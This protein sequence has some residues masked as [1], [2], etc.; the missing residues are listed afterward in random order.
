MLLVT[1]VC[2]GLAYAAERLWQAQLENRLK[3]EAADDIS[4]VRS[5]LENVLQSELWV[6]RG[7]A[8]AIASKPDMNA[9][10][11]QTIVAHLSRNDT[12]LVNIA[13][14][15]G[16]VVS[17][18]YPESGNEAVLGLD[19]NRHPQQGR[20]ALR[21]IEERN[22][23]VAG[24]IK[25]L[26]GG[27]GLVARMPVFVPTA[28]GQSQTLW[29]LVSAVINQ[30]ELLLR[31]GVFMP[32]PSGVR[33]LL[34]GRDALGANGDLF[35]GDAADLRRQDVSWLQRDI[36]LPVGSWRMLGMLP[37]SA[38][39]LPLLTRL[40]LRLGFVLLAAVA[41]GLLLL[42]HKQQ[43]R[44][45]QLL[46]ELQQSQI[47]LRSI[48]DNNSSSLVYLKDLE[49]RYQIVNQ[50][51][52][53][54]KG[55]SIDAIIGRSDYDLV[56]AANAEQFRNNDRYVIE[57]GRSHEFEEVVSLEGEDRFFHSIK[58]PMRDHFGEIVGVCGITTDINERMRSEKQLKE[59]RA[60]FRDLVENTQDWIWEV[61]LNGRYTYSSPQVQD[62]LGYS[63]DEILGKTPFDLMSAAEAERLQKLFQQLLQQQ[64]PF[65]N[66][67]KINRHKDGYEVTLE[68]NGT[69]IFDA[70]GAFKGFRGVNRDISERQLQR[71]RAAYH[72][73]VMEAIAQGQE[74]QKVLQDLLR[75]VQ[76]QIPA[77]WACL[78]FP[79][80]SKDLPELLY[81]SLPESLRDWFKRAERL[82][83]L[84][85][86]ALHNGNFVSDVGAQFG[87][88]SVEI[89][90]KAEGPK[91]W[92]AWPLPVQLEQ[93]QLF[94]CMVLLLAREHRLRAEQMQ[95][96]AYMAHLAGIALDRMQ[97][98]QRI[99]R[100]ETWH[101]ILI[102]GSQDG[103]VIMHANGEVHACN[104]AFAE[105]LQYPREQ[106]LKMA[107]WD[108]DV[109]WNRQELIDMVAS[110]DE[111][112]H[113]FETLHQRRD[114]I[115]LNVDV[116]A[117]AAS[118]RGEKMLFCVCRDISDKKL[119]ELALQ[120]SREQFDL[121][122]RASNDGLWD[123][124]LQ[125]NEVYYS[126][127]WKAMLGY[128]ED[129]LDN[130]F[131]TWEELVHAEDLAQAKALIEQ[132]LAQDQDQYVAEFRMRH[133]Q[134]H[135]VYILSR[136]MHL[137]DEQGVSRRMVGTH[138]D[139]SAQKQLELRLRESEE[140]SRLII[141][142]S[143]D[144]IIVTDKAGRMVRIN[145][146]TETVFGYR[147][148]ELLGHAVE[149]LIPERY[150]ADHPAKREKF[151]QS[152]THLSMLDLAGV[153]FIGRRKDGSEFPIEAGLTPVSLDGKTHIIVTLKD[154]TASRNAEQALLQ[155]K[156]ELALERDFIDAVVEVAGNIIAVLDKEGRYVRFNHAAEL[157]S[158]YS[159]EELLGHS[160]WD[161][162]IP[163]ECQAGVKALFA[164]LNQGSPFANSENEWIC[165]DG[166]RRLID[167][168]NTI[169]LDDQQ[170]PAFI[171]S[172][173]YDITEIRAAE[174]ALQHS[175]DEL[176]LR[177]AERTQELKKS[178]D[179]N[180]LLFAKTPIG[181]ALC[182]LRGQIKDVNPAF[183][184]I[185]GCDEA[186]AKSLN[187]WEIGSPGEAARD[188]LQLEYLDQH[189]RYGPL[190]TE[191][192]QKSGKRV[193]VS[194]NGQR[195]ELDGQSYIWS[196][197]EDLTERR[198]ME[199]KIAASEAT[200]IRAQALA[201]LGSW[202]LDLGS[203]QLDWS[204]ETYQIF[205]KEKGSISDIRQFYACVHVDDVEMVRER[206]MS[207]QTQGGD[208]DVEHRIVVNGELRWVRQQAELQYDADGCASAAIG[209]VLDISGFK[210]AELATRQAL[211][212]AHRLAQARSN[213]LANM[214]HEIR[215]PLNG[216]L[217]L[218]QIGQR[219]ADIT[220]SKIFAQINESGE[221][222]LR[223]VN[224]ILDFSKLDAGKMPMESEAFDLHQSLQKSHRLMLPKALEKNLLLELEISQ[225]VPEWVQGDV[226]RLEQIIV[227]LLSNALKFT[228]QGKVSLLV[229][230]LD[231]CLQ[232]RVVD[233]GIG[234][235][236]QQLHK[237][238]QPFE[239]AD[240]STTRQFG[241][242]GLG[243]A[244]CYQLS[245]QMHGDIRVRSKL[246]EGTEFELLL[247]LPA[248]QA[249]ARNHELVGDRLR[250]AGLRLLAA[251]DVELNRE[252]LQDMIE[253]EGAEIDLVENGELA[254]AAVKSHP[255]EFYDAVLMDV[256]MP[257]MDGYEATRQI[258]A[259]NA[260]LPV[261]GI[262]AHALAEER[263]KA[264][265][266]GMAEHISKPVRLEQ[267][268][269]AILDVVKRQ[270]RQP[271]FESVVSQN[272]GA[273][274]SGARP[275]SLPGIDL[276]AGLN[277][278]Q[279]RWGSYERILHLFLQQHEHSI[280]QL[281]EH[282]QH[283]EL[284]L[285]QSLAHRLKGSSGNLGAMGLHQASAQLEQAC[286]E[287]DEV[288]AQ[289]LLPLV[290]S[291][292]NSVLQG[293]REHFQSQPSVP[294]SSS[295][296]PD[297]ET[298]PETRAHE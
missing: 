114:G 248:T 77:A 189:G 99:L 290:K 2:L 206:W 34:R 38:A 218:A 209:T 21:A 54:E 173:G 100:D 80:E 122:M 70:N 259:L 269:L 163:E 71:Q 293:L 58:F 152:A 14:A 239:Q 127:R 244:I 200:L 266:S 272:P 105:L 284:S 102:E 201:H 39:Q 104:R 184:E 48:I 188:T 110:I 235:D 296:H 138:M 151:A 85:E 208:Y 12:T 170:Q 132:T 183:L 131:A 37:E 7:L 172:Q 275:E 150:R 292:L 155:S 128:A 76:Q 182:D 139:I 211:R 27:E 133:K 265:M 78:L 32:Q 15:P 91:H 101:K 247:P 158:G 167:W 245:Q 97:Q 191:Y 228:P 35:Y 242:S 40:G 108:W 199:A 5:R 238:F 64:K 66:L 17:M 176:E 51:F 165:K 205:Q 55:M 16:L 264:L 166:T 246:G 59:S 234:I 268:L 106:I 280:E 221:N 297:T 161:F 95:L 237:L 31:A 203:G 74:T 281:Q 28:D 41:I 289:Q 118:F 126:P 171:V 254:V 107:V 18:V 157:I 143:P 49:G 202:H 261:I 177:V 241:G 262:T 62:L 175:R 226:F 10:E 145:P 156:Q 227:N 243:L 204:D 236:K 117:T 63:S 276:E 67:E 45:Q 159:A 271:V 81:S 83:Q 190:E 3:A 116:T 24:P 195:I 1:T 103:I 53:N 298:Q 240:S 149:M 36:V 217:G 113:R 33:F 129:E 233:T 43:Q 256:Q 223:V 181:L 148:A 231:D 8:A 214:S 73:H 56:S 42:R 179:Y 79:E 72:L 274:G 267:L 44:Q 294:V 29:G 20:A 225:E 89:E 180:Q 11:Y 164:Q 219:D 249:G 119:N 278:L 96:L 178:S 260:E 134:G 192:R 61:D 185:I 220:A 162:L 277:R 282:L 153:D 86:Q 198:K 52:A 60:L 69:P 213:F 270:P 136:G 295:H 6:L 87:F 4:Q 144:C 98:Q 130:R 283:S 263:E 125:T 255:D 135:W 273:R 229:Q 197:I 115:V 210:Q 232:F 187:F 174:K 154:I 286:R 50:A 137:F 186:E 23:V 124:D 140:Q 288:L 121:A 253:F 287:A 123:W 230:K 142:S 285:A 65:N 112:G 22:I 224:D 25:L 46:L 257:V 216:V 160:V 252:L 258:H 196:T 250:L 147:K 19:Y 94:G 9:A 47:R 93:G 26:Q 109:K 212:E 279:Q 120:Q 111:Q 82:P 92:L 291:S 88:E 13:A 84:S 215:T 169:L 194:L 251:E 90:V 57:S 30:H 146:Q 193:P 141:D 68:A 222:L 207:A 75:Y 168:R